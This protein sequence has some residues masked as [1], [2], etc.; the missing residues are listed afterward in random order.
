MRVVIRWT[1]STRA[2]STR[3]P[4]VNRKALAARQERIRDLM[5]LSL[6]TAAGQAHP[7]HSALLTSVRQEASPDRL[8]DRFPVIDRDTYFF[9]RERFLNPDSGEP[10]FQRFESPVS[11]LPRTAILM[12]GFV[13]T[14][15]IMCFPEGWSSDLEHFRPES[16]AG[17]VSMLRRMATSV[18]NR[19]AHFPALKRPIV[20]FTGLPFGDAGVLTDAD[21]DQFWKAFSVPVHEYFLGH[22]H[23]VL[24]RECDA[25]SGL[26][27][28]PVQAVVEILDPEDTQVA[29]RRGELIV[30]SLA[31]NLFPAVRL[32]SGLRGTLTEAPCA[33]G[34]AGQRILQIQPLAEPKPRARAAMASHSGA[35]LE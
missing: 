10:G 12:E 21:R 6:G 22:R 17:P 34:I 15:K 35:A 30:T 8:L 18:F 28:D 24:A 16:L 27:I 32:T 7:G 19:G 2:K 14:E 23:E 4:K 9:D 11:P 20:A 29:D 26:H 25:R 13:E 31:N 5:L 3:S 33:C 1:P